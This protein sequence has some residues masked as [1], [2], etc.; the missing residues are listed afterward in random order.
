MA[1]RDLYRVQVALL[2]RL[3]P[4]VA[5]ETCFALKGG[6]AINLFIRDM[7]RLS[8]DIDLTYIPI[9]PRSASL[10]SIDAALKRIADRTRAH[11]HGAQVTETKTDAR[12]TKLLVRSQGVQVKI[13]VTPVLRGCVFPPEMVGVSP[14]VEDTFGF[15]EMQ[16]V[17]FA[18]LYAGKAVA[19]LDRQSPRDFFD[20]RELLANESIDDSLR[21]AFVVYLLSHDRPMWEVLAPHRR[22]ILAEF[23][24]GFDG[25]TDEPVTIEELVAAREALIDN[26]VGKM[27]EEHRRFLLSFERGEPNWPLLRLPDASEL[28]AV[29]WRQLNLDKLTAEKRAALVARLEKVLFD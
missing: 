22:D 12:I 13:E 14:T 3:L 27:P 21:G 9:E 6:T 19:A 25:M 7:P 8:V 4:D 10:N 28:P 2:V 20:V 26:I 16:L 5:T 29:K 18:D 11:I 1:F 15:A 23:M 24:H 17:S